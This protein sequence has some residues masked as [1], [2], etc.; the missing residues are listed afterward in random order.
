MLQATFRQLQI[1]MTV[2]QEGGFARAA[3]RLCISQAGISH[4]VRALERQLDCQLFH[5]RM[6]AA[7]VLS[8]HGEALLRQV[9]ALLERASAVERLGASAVAG[10]VPAVRVGAGEYLLERLFR[11]AMAEFQ[12]RHPRV[13][14]AFERIGSAR[15]AQAEIRR[16]RLD[17][18]YFTVHK[19][20]LDDAVDVLAS[21]KVG[22][23]AAPGDTAARAAGA[24][25]TSTLALIMPQ[26]GS[27][28]ERA[29]AG[30]L[31]TAGVVDY[32]PVARAQYEETMVALAALGVGACCVFRESVQAELMEGKLV[33]LQIELPRVF[34]CAVR[35]PGALAQDH[36]RAFDRFAAALIQAPERAAPA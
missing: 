36:L 15:E 12:L 3:D 34:R 33:E 4:H 5:R 23:F 7:A 16:G 2:A 32:H 25:R 10:E 29:V 35:S 26:A 1:F 18:A 24:G 28:Q 22:L 17:L 19:L 27:V 21:I 20:G 13:Q 30:I 6:G 9:P 31:E 8:E 14:V 11:P